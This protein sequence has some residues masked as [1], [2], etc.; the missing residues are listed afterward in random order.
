MA[1]L[2]ADLPEN[3][4]S[5]QIISPNGTEVG[6]D[7]KHG[8]NYLMKQV[9]AAQNETNA[10]NDAVDNISLENLGVKALTVSLT[11]SGWTASLTQSVTAT[12]VTAVSNVIVSPAPSSLDAYS[13]AGVR[14]TA[15][16]ANSLTFQCKKKPTEALSV[17]VLCL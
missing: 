11:A 7:A 9:N 3:W 1:K 2:P 12:G 4:T 13:S 16:A 15:Q 14:C 17:E 6:L 5:G 8:Y 10:L